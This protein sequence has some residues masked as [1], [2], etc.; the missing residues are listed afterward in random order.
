M[1][2]ETLSILTR[3]TLRQINFEDQLSY[4]FN[5]SGLALN[6]DTQV[7][8]KNK[9]YLTKMSVELRD[10]ARRGTSYMKRALHNYLIW[11]VAETYVQ[12]GFLLFVCLF[13]YLF[14]LGGE[15]GGGGEVS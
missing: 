8:I 13:V 7:V 2:W 12:V 3:Q 9:L 5:T 10:L 1:N 4:L 6:K 11:R 15:R 14:L